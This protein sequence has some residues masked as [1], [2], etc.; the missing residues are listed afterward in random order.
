MPK[1][2]VGLV[3]KPALFNESLLLRPL[4]CVPVQSERVGIPLCAVLVVGVRCW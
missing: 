2:S 1:M 4:S 3:G